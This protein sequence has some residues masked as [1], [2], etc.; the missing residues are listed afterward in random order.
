MLLFENF[1]AYCKYINDDDDDD[2]DDVTSLLLNSPLSPTSKCQTG[3]LWNISPAV[4]WGQG[5]RRDGVSRPR[6]LDG[7]G[8]ARGRKC[9]FHT[10]LSRISATSTPFDL[11]SFCK[12]HPPQSNHAFRDSFLKNK[13]KELMSILHIGTIRTFPRNAGK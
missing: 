8:A 11:L 10:K 2:D 7:T 4:S 1:L 5:C 9:P 13:L 6:C 3:A 12:C